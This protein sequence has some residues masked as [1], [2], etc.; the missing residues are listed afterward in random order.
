VAGL[1]AEGRIE[2]QQTAALTVPPSA[3]V[4]EGDRAFAWRLENGILHKVSLSL[5]DRDPRTG[6]FVLKGGLEEGDMLVRYPTTTLHD[7][8]SV[9]MAAR[10]D[11]PALG[12]AASVTRAGG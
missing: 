9:E 5:G 3:L 12:G 10:I 7:G 11:S 4:R 6:E 8:Q 2:T 1:Y